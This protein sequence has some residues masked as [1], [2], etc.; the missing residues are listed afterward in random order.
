MAELSEALI[1]AITVWPDNASAPGE[2]VIQEV[3]NAEVPQAR[4]ETQPTP[5]TAVGQIRSA[6]GTDE[7]EV[8]TRVLLGP[9][10]RIV[11]ASI[12]NLPVGAD[13]PEDAT[14]ALRGAPTRIGPAAIASLPSVGDVVEETRPGTASRAAPPTMIGLAPTP[15]RTHSG[16]GTL[17]FVVGF[18]VA[19]VFGG[20]AGVQLAPT[21]IPPAAPPERNAVATYLSGAE[22]LVAQKRYDGAEDLLERARALHTADAALNVKLVALTDA[23][24]LEV[25]DHKLH[26]ALAMGDV[27]AARKELQKL[28]SVD[29][30]ADRLASLR[31]EIEAAAKATPTEPAND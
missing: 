5:A 17:T 22:T 14:N 6:A 12:V 23:V 3:V 7:L 28:A 8:D 16:P 10:A 26:R 19:L 31:Q 27:E 11:A 30:P 15:T 4:A 25:G 2:K 9:P 1:P 13:E 21:L 29:T 18:V 24:R 20:V